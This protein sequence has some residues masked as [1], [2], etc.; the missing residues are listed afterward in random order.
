MAASVL[1]DY[2]CTAAFE[3][4]LN[5]INWECYRAEPDARWNPT[6]HSTKSDLFTQGWIDQCMGGVLGNCLTGP[7]IIQYIVFRCGTSLRP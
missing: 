1:T 4:N 7:K 6:I 2:N 5:G 3:N